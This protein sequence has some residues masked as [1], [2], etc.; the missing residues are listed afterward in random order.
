MEASEDALYLLNAVQ[1]EIKTDLEVFSRK[2]H[3]LFCGGFYV[4]LCRRDAHGG[5]MGTIK[6]ATE[7]GILAQER[8]LAAPGF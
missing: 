7:R 1:G 3:G 2:F 6:M 8:G 4:C 5:R